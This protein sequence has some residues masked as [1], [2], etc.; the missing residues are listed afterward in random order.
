MQ[1]PT[2]GTAAPELAVDLVGGGSFKLADAQPEHFTMLVFYRGKHCPVCRSYLQTLRDVR[3]EYAELGVDLVAISMDDEG[4]A[5]RSVEEW[6]IGDLDV[7]HGLR[8]DTAR[9]WGLYLSSAIKDG[10]PDLF[11]EP[12]LFLVRSD[13]TLHYAAVNSMPFGR[14]DL[15]RFHT[16]INWLLENDYPS[17][18]EVG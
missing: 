9:D 2:P 17:R 7:G 5:T 3:D 15:E 6:E 1:T 18:G 11:S 14:P 16:S 4:R 13:G 10:E 8:E 12:G